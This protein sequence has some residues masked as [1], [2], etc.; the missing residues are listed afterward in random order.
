MIDDVDKLYEMMLLARDQEKYNAW[1]LFQPYPKQQEF[2]QLG[3]TFKERMLTAGNQTGNCSAENAP[4]NP[5]CCSHD[6]QYN[7]YE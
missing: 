2:M 3:A 6:C 5:V 7:Q 1:M 4:G